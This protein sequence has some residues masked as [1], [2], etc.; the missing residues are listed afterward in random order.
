M[1][2]SYVKVKVLSG[3]KSKEIKAKS[4]TTGTLLA[5][6]LWWSWEIKI[7]MIHFTYNYG[8]NVLT[9]VTSGKKKNHC[10]SSPTVKII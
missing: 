2:K 7:L 4:R 9:S 5:G 6:L 1:L 10:C 3:K 8:I